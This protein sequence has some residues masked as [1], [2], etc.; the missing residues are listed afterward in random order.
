[1][2]VVLMGVAGSGKTT[3][4][5][6][7]SDQLGWTFVEG[8]DFHPP[9]NVEKMRRGE[10]LTDADRVPWLRALRRRIDELAAAGRS[11]VVACSAL[12]QAYRDVLASGRPE[13]RFVWLTAAPGV[14]RD[15]LERRTGHYMPP[16]LLE[17]QLET[18]EEPAGVPVVDVT[19]PPAEVAAAIRQRLGL[20]PSASRSRSS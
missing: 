10:P 16:V 2:I 9:A 4:G 8:D 17:S 13:V 5:R 15:R 6:L 12:K 11:A 7:L 3:V 14:I 19:P 1:V 20:Q 18:L